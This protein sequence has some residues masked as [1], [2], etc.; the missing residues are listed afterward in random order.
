[1]LSIDPRR[2]PTAATPM[3]TV[4]IDQRALL[5]LYA[6]RTERLAAFL[7]DRHDPALA[8]AA[9]NLAAGIRGIARAA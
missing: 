4:P 8:A 9:R 7:D 6:E 1:M 3:R 5:E 2:N